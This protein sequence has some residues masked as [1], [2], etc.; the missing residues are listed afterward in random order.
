[1]FQL[2]QE[3]NVMKMKYYEMM[4]HYNK[5]KNDTE[6]LNNKNKNEIEHLNKIISFMKHQNMELN[7][8]IVDKNK[9]VLDLIKKNNNIGFS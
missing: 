9:Q 7:K 2:V 5:M 3:N 1:M 4:S 6:L 8:T